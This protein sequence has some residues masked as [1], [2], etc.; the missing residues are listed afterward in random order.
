MEITQDTDKD[1]TM[2]A[3]FRLDGEDI[4][5][6][7]ASSGHDVHFSE[8]DMTTN[9]AVSQKIQIGSEASECGEIH[10]VKS[11]LVE[12]DDSVFDATAKKALK[13]LVR[14]RGDWYHFTYMMIHELSL[15]LA[16][17]EPTI[18]AAFALGGVGVALAMFVVRR[19]SVKPVKSN[20]YDE[21]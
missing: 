7:K 10:R 9:G 2:Y 11:I 13:G 5:S 14:E 3:D 18:W 4:F 21:I 8:N 20:A 15:G 16:S 19:L 6:A 1:N 12:V 17:G